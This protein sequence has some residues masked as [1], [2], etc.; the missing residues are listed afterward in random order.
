MANLEASFEA[1]CIA[2]CQELTRLGYRP[3]YFLQMIE[4]YGG[5]ETARRLIMNE[6]ASAG[7]RR[8]WEMQRLDM[9]IEAFVLKPEY[10]SLFNQEERAK[11]RQRLEELHYRAPWDTGAST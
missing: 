9:T 1:A 11:A 7:F 5:V 10:R 8:L 3:T 6:Q 2:G 4:M